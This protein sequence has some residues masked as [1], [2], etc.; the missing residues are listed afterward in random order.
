MIQ[1]YNKQMEIINDISTEGTYVSRNTA[2][3]FHINVVVVLQ[4][5]ISHVLRISC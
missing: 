1:Q 3:F 5:F 4:N 2:S